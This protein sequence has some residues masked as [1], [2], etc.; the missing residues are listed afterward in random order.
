MDPEPD[1]I[2]NEIEQTRE[3]LTEKIEKVE[4]QFKDTLGSV[5]DTLTGVKDTVENTIDSVKEKVQDTVQSVTSTVE[6]TVASVKQ[7]FDVPQQVRR[8]PWALAGCSLVA[9]LAAGYFLAGRRGAMSWAYR[10]AP[11]R[12]RFDGRAGYQSSAGNYQQPAASNYQPAASSYQPAASVQPSRAEPEQ[13]GLLTRLLGPFESEIDKVKETAI[14]VLIGLMRDTLKRSLPPTL[15]ANVDEI[16]DSAT[17][18][19]GGKPVAGPVLSSEF[20][21]D[22]ARAGGAAR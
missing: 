5:K 8:H 9:G 15:A 17:R 22:S 20:G 2:R 18:K 12:P 14:G 1:V 7:T 10:S 19:A 16:M 11:P 21:A 3:S 4:E 6:G 13:P